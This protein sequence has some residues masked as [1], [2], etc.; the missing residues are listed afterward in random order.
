VSGSST[1]SFSFIV[2][3][4]LKLKKDSLR[5]MK[6]TNQMFYDSYIYNENDL[7]DPEPIHTALNYAYP[8]EEMLR[9][10]E[11]TF[12]RRQRG[13]EPMSDSDR[14]EDVDNDSEEEVDFDLE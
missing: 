9:Y 14:A 5:L 7:K 3:P 8:V 13:E 4:G 6:K 12:N 10:E 2:V 11:E 1:D